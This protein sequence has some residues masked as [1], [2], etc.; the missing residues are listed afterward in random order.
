MPSADRGSVW[1]VDLGL[2]AKVRPYLVL[3]LFVAVVGLAGYPVW[4]EHRA[5]PVGINRA[6]YDRIKV[7]MTEA[8]VEAILG[9]PPGYYGKMLPP[10]GGSVHVFPSVTVKNWDSDGPNIW[11]YFSPDGRV[12]DKRISPENEL[13]PSFLL[14]LLIRLNGW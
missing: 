10:C 3:G 14:R 9:G 6:G 11:V 13:R 1:V 8:E 2:V 4:R 12:V 7:G 5:L